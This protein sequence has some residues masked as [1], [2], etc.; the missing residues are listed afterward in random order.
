MLTAF[1]HLHLHI[2]SDLFPVGLE[3]FFVHLIYFVRATGLVYHILAFNINQKISGEEFKFQTL[4]LSDC[5]SALVTSPF[6]LW[7]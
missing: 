6:Y 3:K 7:T 2:P 5:S 1:F 4:S